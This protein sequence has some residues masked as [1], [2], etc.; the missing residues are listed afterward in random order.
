MMEGRS[1]RRASFSLVELLVVIAVI[2][3]LTSI[4][5][6]ALGKAKDTAKGIVCLGNLK[7]IGL[8][9]S[10]YSDDYDQWIVPMDV[11]TYGGYGGWFQMLAGT[12]MYAAPQQNY[13]VSFSRKI[14][15]SS[16]TACV[17]TGT[18]ACPNEPIGWG[19]Y[20]DTPPQF[21]N[22]HYGV[23]LTACG[24]L[25]M[26][27]GALLIGATTHRLNAIQNASVAVFA[28]DTNTRQM[29]NI[30]NVTLIAYRHGA[31]DPRLVTVYQDAYAVLPFS[32]FKG[33]TNVL[34]FDGHAAARTITELYNQKDGSGVSD[35]S[36]FARAGI[37]Q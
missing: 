7:T 15:N 20:T 17:A 13:G 26:S 19:L 22:T 29:G 9:Q 10:G 23:N 4:L 36:S 27:G 2:A 18:F 30:A 33:R 16:G 5:L 6:P 32:A 14:W 31:P 12:Y 1:W 8:A 35:N 37:R 21:L 25:Y 28:A 3:I 34:C 24:Y 11:G